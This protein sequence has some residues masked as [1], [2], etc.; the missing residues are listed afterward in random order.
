MNA[1]IVEPPQSTGAS[2][3]LRACAVLVSAALCACDSMSTPEILSCAGALA[4]SVLIGAAAGSGKGAAIGVGAG[5]AAC[6]AIHFAMR[7]TRDAPQVEADYLRAHNGQLPPQPIIYRADISTQPS[8]VVQHGSRFLVVSNL[9]AVRGESTQINDVSAEIR[10]FAYGKTEP[11][12]VHRQDVSHDGGSGAYEAQFSVELPNA[13][14]QG[15]YRVEAVYFLN[16]Q[17]ADSRS[18]S[19]QVV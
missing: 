10:F 18:V 19:L 7:K 16:Q 6:V 2:V 3:R 4:A 15:R 17:P 8:Q 14:P 9:E 5:A 12:F 1:S 13:M 11:I